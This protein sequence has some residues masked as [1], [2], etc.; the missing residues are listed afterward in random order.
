MKIGRSHL[1]AFISK[2]DGFTWSNGLLLDQ[3]KDV[4]YPDG[5]QTAEGTIYITYDYKRRSDQKIYLT[6][7]SED[8]VMFGTSKTILEVYNRR[9]LI[10]QGG[11]Q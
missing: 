2:D 5:Q 10:S 3:R 7:F 11:A 9:M 1:M 4:S 6:N 8:D